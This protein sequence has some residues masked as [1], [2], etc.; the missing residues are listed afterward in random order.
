[1]QPS[2]KSTPQNLVPRSKA[3]LIS[4]SMMFLVALILTIAAQY[5]I[6]SFEVL[7]SSFGADLPWLCRAVL[8]YRKFLFIIPLY[9]SIIVIFLIVQARVTDDM[10]QVFKIIFLPT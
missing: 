9:M 3:I 1:M 10:N 6:P 2:E 5:I 8:D 7:F 4:Y